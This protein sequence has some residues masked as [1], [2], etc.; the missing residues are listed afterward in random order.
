MTDPVHASQ[1][2]GPPGPS[3][4]PNAE[5][6]PTPFLGREPE[7]RRLRRLFEGI[8]AG[9]GGALVVSGEAGIGKSALVEQALVGVSDFRLLRTLGVEPE[10]ELGY[11]A[12]QHVCAEL[13]AEA[14]K[15]TEPQASALRVALGEESGPPPDRFLVGLATL[16]L[17]AEAGRAG[18][19]LLLVDDAHWLDRASAQ[20]LGFVARRLKAEAAGA[21]FITRTD[22]GPGSSATGDLDALPA[23]E[24]EGLKDDDARQ[25]L[26]MSYPGAIDP[27]VEDRVVAES[28][29]NP[30]ALLELPRGFTPAEL[31]GGFGFLE[32]VAVPRRVEESFRRQVRALPLPLRQL[33]LIAACEPT[34]EPAKLW[35]AAEEMRLDLPP[36]ASIRAEV[37]ELLQLG[38]RVSFR[39]PLLRSAVYHQSS[40][41]ERRRVHGALAAVTDPASDPD[42]RAWHRAQALVGTDLEVA[43][44]LDAAAQRAAAR[45]AP[46]AAGALYERSAEVSPDAA[47][48][49]E[50]T[51][52][53]AEADCL[54]G[55]TEASHRLLE[56]LPTVCAERLAARTQL[57]R[58][59]LAFLVERDRDASLMLLDASIRLEPLDT[60]LAV[61]TRL[62]ALQAAWFAGQI[63]APG[64]RARLFAHDV[65]P[66]P[67]EPM[68]PATGLLLRSLALR[69]EHGFTATVPVLAQA[70]DEFIAHPPALDPVYRRLWFSAVHA[71]DLLRDDQ[72]RMLTDRLVTEVRSSGA[73]S[74]SLLALTFHGVV[75]AV[76]GDLPAARR[77]LVEVNAAERG[78]EL[79]EPAYAD[80]LLTAWRGQPR[81]AA[82]ATEVAQQSQERGEGVGLVA[83]DWARAILWNGTGRYADAL[84]HAQR[85]LE[86]QDEV[87]CLTF[88]PAAEALIAAAHLKD[89]SAA[90]R[91]MLALEPAV[92]SGSNWAMGLWMRG[93]A[94]TATD[95]EADEL[96]NKALE[97]LGR[98]HVATEIARTELYYGEW[99]RR[100][101]RKGPAATHLRRAY[102][103][104][105]EQGA[106]GFA[107]LAAHE[108]AAA[109][110]TIH[111]PAADPSGTLTRQ[112]MAIVELARQGLTNAEIASRLFI[113]ARTVEW[114][115]GRSYAKL[116]ITS[117]RELRPV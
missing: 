28:Q 90:E 112:E 42:R 101:G 115:L 88:L 99:L 98:T 32:G 33:L 10:H 59:Q 13:T 52:K 69:Y 97:L 67:D 18:P 14:A 21:L 87:G 35:G 109:G 54:A 27:A 76:T 114:H 51:L 64:K 71:L 82:V 39:H 9:G 63:M 105:I 100:R 73:T 3:S 83:A 65:R 41:N 113:S 84:D 23:L 25:L 4:D 57:L 47:Q 29:G 86:G 62:E 15:L 53:A 6:F 70:L 48:R 66:A 93:Q 49:A 8:R 7:V 31:S 1:G 16:S 77:L 75:L 110:A 103:S 43:D 78:L 72:T 95:A 61:D 92:A 96:F 81:G 117:R 107:G 5:P 17:L 79:H 20:V 30:L 74:L 80:L 26:R 91:A 50:R 89:S 38:P 106:G 108:L 56:L 34:G 55:L 58:A 19:V 60:E 94:M 2:T 46:A 11:A 37:G 68:D 22:A 102:D 24:L 111:P 36:H 85:A 40:A 44:E 12:L 45:G 116:G 104:F